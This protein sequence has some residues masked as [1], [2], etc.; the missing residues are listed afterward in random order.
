ML[1]LHGYVQNG[2]V[3]RERTGSLRKAVKSHDFVFIDAPHTVTDAFPGSEKRA[4]DADGAGTDPRGWWTAGEN[5]EAQSGEW[6]RPS[7]SRSAVGFDASLQLLQ[8][9]VREHGPFDGVLGFSQGAA[10]A[11][12]LL[13][14]L[15]SSFR[16]AVLVAGFVP[17]DDALAARV[18]GAAPLP[19]AVLS[20]SGDAD[21]LVSR[22]RVQR[23][24]S[25]FDPSRARMFTHPGG[26]G[27]PSNAAFR[28]AVRD[29][30]A[31]STNP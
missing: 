28:Q 26:H 6:V 14:A 22:E 21:A 24:A 16:W 15:P 27:I 29:F 19:H 4:E 10:T 11:G 17:H 25:C 9:Y 8:D 1:C 31:E 30:I 2:A 18:E 3:F 13:A 5:A 7:V 23:L 20:V 12:L